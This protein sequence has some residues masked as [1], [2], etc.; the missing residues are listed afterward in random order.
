MLNQ[1][2]N[3]A[4]SIA[5]AAIAAILTAIIKVVGNNVVDYIQAKKGSIAVKTGIDKYN[6]TLQKA[7]SIWAIVDEEF[8]ITPTLEKTIENKQ[9]MFDKLLKSKIPTLTDNEI[10]DIRQAIAGEVNKG[11]E[12]ITSDAIATQKELEVVKSQNSQLTT[13]NDQLKQKLLTIQT[14]ATVQSTPQ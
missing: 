1:I 7:K 9:E 14:A 10:A 6:A 11:K 5:V 13:E 8:R 2:I 4:V 3:T 12:V